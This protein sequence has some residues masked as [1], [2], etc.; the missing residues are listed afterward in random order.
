[1]LQMEPQSSCPEMLQFCQ[2]DAVT[3]GKVNRIIYYLHAAL[4]LL[5]ILPKQ[6]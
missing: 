4:N 3:M 6:I 5:D 2:L 1:M